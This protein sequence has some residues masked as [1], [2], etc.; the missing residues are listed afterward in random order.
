ML[1]GALLG[2]AGACF[3]QNVAPDGANDGDDVISPV[4][5]R[6]SPERKVLS[7]HDADKK[8]AEAAAPLVQGDLSESILYQFLISEIAGQRGSSAL[9]IKG[10]GGLAKDTRDPRI[11]R[12]ALELAFQ[13]RQFPQAMEAAALWLELEPNSVIAQ[14]AMT[15]LVNT[16]GD[17]DAVK[18]NLRRMLSNKEKAPGFYLQLNAIFGRF[19]DKAAVLKQVQELAALHPQMAEAHF[20]ISQAAAIARNEKLAMVEARGALAINAGFQQAAILLGHLLR[21][22]SED[23]ALIFFRDYLTS[24][25]DA[26]DVR[27]AYARMLAAKKIYPSARQEFRIAEK[28]AP[29]DPEIPYAIAL[30]AL[31]MED[32]AGAEL[33]FHR[34]LD[35]SPQDANPVLIGL[36]QV[37]EGRKKWDAAI[38]WYRQVGVG[39]YFVAAQLKIAGVLNKKEG[40]A[41]GRKYL[42]DAE[43]ATKE[44][45]LQFI[46]AESQ[47]LRDAQ[48][49]R[50]AHELLTKALVKYPDSIELLY[51]RA[52]I[53]E[54]LGRIAELE[55]DLRRVIELKP[56]HAHAY[57]ALG[58]TLADRTTRFEEAYSL[59]QKAIVL[60][61]DDAFIL[62]SLG[63][64]QYRQ[65]KTNDSLRTLKKAYSMRRDPEIAAHLGEVLWAAGSRD[66]AMQLWRGALQENPGNDALVG[67]LQKF[68]R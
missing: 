40:I 68:Q 41:A 57:N 19:A 31:Q 43:A 4:P 25:P 32:Y 48:A 10:M 14:Q 9:A 49:L 50:E 61:P 62:D 52:M 39:D 53:A 66:E 58:Y 44:Q 3:A 65:G 55:T 30:V 28:S 42:Q 60:A 63:W 46:L 45:R 54:K 33:D 29:M 12:R 26:K 47:L 8:S 21:E 35:L 38:D 27:M 64:V 36:G 1:A 13:S 24:H 7:P 22:T 51:D 15:V 20:A 37:E 11:A 2:V 34:A 6:E 23:E 5:G 18:Q 56:D 59:I 17:L 16:H 67:I